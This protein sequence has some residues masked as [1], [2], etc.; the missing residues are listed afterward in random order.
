MWKL[1]VQKVKK[2]EFDTK[3]IEK[4]KTLLTF[5]AIIAFLIGLLS[6]LSVL[7]VKILMSLNYL[8]KSSILWTTF[9][10]V[11]INFGNVLVAVCAGSLII[12]YYGFIDYMRQR[13]R[14]VLIEDDFLD[15]LTNDKMEKLKN[16]LE[17]RLLYTNIKNVPTDSLFYVVQDEI[18]PLLKDPFYKEYIT[19]VDCE[20]EDNLIKKTIN[21]RMV[22]SCLDSCHNSP[23]YTDDTIDC[24]SL[25]SIPGKQGK[26]IFKITKFEYNNTSVL[27]KIEVSYPRIN[28]DIYNIGVLLD[29]SKVKNDLLISGE[30][31]ILET[32]YVTLSPIEDTWF[33][34]KINK[35]C[36][37]YCLH[38]NY[39]KEDFEVRG[40]GFG[41]MD[42]SPNGRIIKKNFST[43]I[44]IRFVDWILPGDGVIFVV[45]KIS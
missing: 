7:I 26:D 39:N 23:I 30:K 45:K 24:A 4:E 17:Q 18:K 34:H 20:I 37:D 42:A 2:D 27:D 5:P 33:I 16:K 25:K 41:F 44:V 40:E 1:V 32:E 3:H 15:I 12:E 10:D 11:L 43:S 35:A 14:D 21:R 9:N 13:I 28:D 6:Y 22:Y 8:N 29:M 31:T 36:K 19:T 38:F